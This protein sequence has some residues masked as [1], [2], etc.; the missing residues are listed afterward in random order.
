MAQPQTGG[1]PGKYGYDSAGNLIQDQSPIQRT[2]AYILGALQAL[3]ALGGGGGGGGGNVVITGTTANG[4][5]TSA[6]SNISPAGSVTIPAGAISV[7][8]L[9][10]PSAAGTVNGITFD[11]TTSDILTAYRL[12]S[13]TWRPLAAV[14][15]I[16]T[17]GTGVLTVQ[18]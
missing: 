11:N 2:L 3:V 5:T 7:E 12:D 1:P 8:F 10:F 14:T 4:N 9:F 6:G 18:T 13:P 15:Y 17:A 16:L